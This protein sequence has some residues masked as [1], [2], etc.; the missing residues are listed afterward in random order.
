MNVTCPHC[1]GSHPAD[2]VLCPVTGSPMPAPENPDPQT[3][4]T[5]ECPHCGEPHPLGLELCLN[6]SREM[7]APAATVTDV[8]TTSV[9]DP[10][11][12]DRPRTTGDPFA[13]DGPAAVAGLVRLRFDWG[14]VVE[15]GDGDMLELGRDPAWCSMASHMSD[16]ISSQHCRIQV[17]DG[18]ATVTDLRSTNG[19][20]VDG[21]RIEPLVAVPM[22]RDCRLASDPP[23]LV[24]LE[25]S[26]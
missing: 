24:T 15:L 12:A 9:E 19:T 8:P 3:E 6:T 7:P 21:R 23:V 2:L 18:V 11:D 26:G 16:N 17:R 20:F 10:C 14:Q 13:A 5:V 25:S 1:N 4:E 22:R